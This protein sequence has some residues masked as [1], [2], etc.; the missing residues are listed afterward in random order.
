M[1]KKEIDTTAPE[2]GQSTKPKATR[3]L[4]RPG[5]HRHSI[6]IADAAWVKI[7]SYV[8]ENTFDLDKW[9][10]KQMSGIADSM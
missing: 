6:H 5:Y 1:A 3:N 9:L 4:T 8:D 2:A 7:V 10:T